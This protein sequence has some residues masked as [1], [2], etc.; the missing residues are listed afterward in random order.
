M[1]EN[2]I[3]SCTEDK[4]D[5]EDGVTWFG[6]ATYESLAPG[7]GADRRTALVQHGRLYDLAAVLRESHADDALAV[8]Q[9]LT[10]VISDWYVHG[11]AL[12]A[13]VRRALDAGVP[14]KIGALA[15]GD[16][17]LCVPYQPGRIF[18]TASNYYEH[19]AE[20][21]TKL[22]PR[23]ESS[24]YMFMKA[25]TSVTA[26]DT[27]V[28]LPPHAERV[29]W[30]V[31][32]A[33]V[34]GRPGRHIPVEQAHEWIAGYTVINDVSARDLNRRTD[35][36]FTHDWFRGKS[37]DTFAPLGPWFVPRDVIRD[38]QNL[39]M[40][41]SVNGETMQNDTTAGMIFNIAE[42]IAYLSGILTLKPG[43]LIATGTPTGVGMGRGVYLKAGD[44][45]VAGIEGIGA[46]E[47]R[48]VAQRK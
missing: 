38:P 6:I 16:Y 42:Q 21:G 37:F 34:I 41:L 3:G 39:R 10:S 45:M 19:A 20:M 12:D 32:L 8:A 44:V 29:D 5:K 14:A 46:I 27:E 9:D 36:P 15:T 30:E 25:E 23:S 31:E 1:G 33:V 43:D 13:A 7:A 17:R 11:E 47:N 4:E 26:T 35:Y 2:A 28:V 22:A 24:P 48:V 40:T 18:A